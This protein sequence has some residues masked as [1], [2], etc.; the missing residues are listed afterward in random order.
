MRTPCELR[1][2]LETR[3]G[4]PNQSPYVSDVEIRGPEEKLVMIQDLQDFDEDGDQNSGQIAVARWPL[5][6][7]LRKDGVLP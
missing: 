2:A 5:T 7:W 1:E 6:R 3:Q 4:A